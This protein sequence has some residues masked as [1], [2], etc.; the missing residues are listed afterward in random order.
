MNNLEKPWPCL[1]CDNNLGYIVQGQLMLT[2]EVHANTD[3]S[4]LVVKC[5]KC[6]SRKVWYSNDRLSSLIKELGRE[7]SQNIRSR[8]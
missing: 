6:G 1:A 3:G 8:S 5:T 4:N 7:I 2:G